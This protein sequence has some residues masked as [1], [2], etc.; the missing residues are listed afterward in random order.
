MARWRTSR[1]HSRHVGPL[2]QV[3]MDRARYA[4]HANASSH[5]PLRPG[6][7]AGALLPD[8]TFVAG[9]PNAEIDKVWGREAALLS[10]NPVLPKFWNNDFT[11]ESVG[12]SNVIRLAPVNPQF[13]RSQVLSCGEWQIYHRTIGGF[14]RTYTEQQAAR[15]EEPPTID[16]R[17]VIDCGAGT[18]GGA[19]PS[20]SPPSSSDSSLGDGGDA[21]SRESAGL[22]RSS[23]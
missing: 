3:R 17:Y 8:N 22:R 15:R 6:G 19:S 11:R 7:N 9:S 18:G 21:G 13:V 23:P 14:A 1:L 2:V 4:L 5:P 16:L 10:N 12:A 20:A